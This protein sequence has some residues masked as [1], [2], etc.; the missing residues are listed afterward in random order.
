MKKV[1][2]DGKEA[3]LGQFSIDEDT[4]LFEVF[5]KLWTAA[6]KQNDEVLADLFTGVDVCR[7]AFMEIF[8]SEE[9]FKDH[10]RRDKMNFLM[11]LNAA[12]QMAV[13]R[14]ELL[15]GNGISFY[16]I[17]TVSMIKNDDAATKHIEEEFAKLRTRLDI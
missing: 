10:P 5:D 6:T 14:R 17:W 13:E 16:I 11:S 8:K 9:A 4:D 1:K 12:L 15:I 7:R 3:I 2:I